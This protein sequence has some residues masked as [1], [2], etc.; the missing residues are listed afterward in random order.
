MEGSTQSLHPRVGSWAIRAAILRAIMVL[1][2]RRFVLRCPLLLG[3]GLV[4]QLLLVTVT[5]RAETATRTAAD[6][7]DDVEMLPLREALR[8]NDSLAQ[9][10]FR[11]GAG[12][13]SGAR[14]D[15]KRLLRENPRD[16][17]ILHLLGIAASVDRR[18]TE[19]GSALRRSLRIRPDGWVALEL[20]NLL[21]DKR[22]V[23]AA[24]RL[25]G[26][27]PDELQSDPRVRRAS[28]YV[29]VAGGDPEA[30]LM[31]LQRLEQ[32]AP[33]ADVAY[34][35]AVLYVELGDSAS[36]ADALTRAVQR[37]PSVGRYHRL[38]FEQLSGLARW[39]AL[40]DASSRTGAAAAGGGLDSYYRG[41]ALHRLGRA[42]EAIRAF[43]AVSAHGMPDLVALAGSA[44]YLLQ[45]G[46]FASAEQACRL[47]MKGLD[48]D[49]SLH[50]L[51]GIIL[52]RQER[53]SEALAYYRR[54]VDER[55][56]DADYRF[57]LMLSL[58]SLQRL[59][60]LGDAVDRAVKDFPDDKRFVRFG[61]GCPPSS[62]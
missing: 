51:L 27:L 10:W 23:S 20:V 6:G 60:E 45:L 40:V 37:A 55:A 16:P 61:E 46:A 2:S 21:L 15:I 47:A 53:E 31:E 38:L 41:I 11:I 29:Q 44:A 8:A 33:E 13:A 35:L 56:D 17:N 59:D 19:A 9:A 26:G 42:Q 24:R 30:A 18:S 14:A 5:V 12:D 39:D 50:H 58:C 4:I 57:D 34:Q 32:E 49:P 1:C 22:R 48:S 25:L 43:S 52:T 28:A 7:L 36:A 3:L 54:A 62:R